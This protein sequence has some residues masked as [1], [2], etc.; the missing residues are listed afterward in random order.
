MRGPENK[1]IGECG[2][3]AKETELNHV[4]GGCGL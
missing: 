3:S 4:Q 2:Q 1:E